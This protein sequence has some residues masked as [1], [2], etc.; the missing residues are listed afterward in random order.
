MAYSTSMRFL[1]VIHATE[2]IQSSLMHSYLRKMDHNVKKTFIILSS[3]IIL[4]SCA[5][6]SNDSDSNSLQQT[7]MTNN[8][9]S[10]PQDFVVEYDKNGSVI[11]TE[12]LG[13]G[14]DIV[15][16]DG[17]HIIGEHVFDLITYKETKLITS[18]YI[19]DSV[20][21]ISDYAFL[22][23]YYRDDGLREI[24]MSKNIEYIGKSAF[25][26]CIYLTDVIFDSSTAHTIS[27]DDKAFAYCSSLVNLTLSES[28]LLGKD[29]F[30]GTGLENNYSDNY[31]SLI[32]SSTQSGT[33]KKSAIHNSASEMEIQ[34][35]I[36]P[37]K[38]EV[39]GDLE[40]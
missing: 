18:V 17:I 1:I 34:P 26:N 7:S 13:D 24:R 40:N 33:S 27:I 36:V 14:G 4:S 16:P 10:F 12:Y 30:I 39:K 35:I 28:V 37:E 15:I 5:P 22:C 31:E 32:D 25:D 6:N 9:L 2:K 8:A 29:V 38:D 23:C 21:I 11:L 3:L 20:K 19:P